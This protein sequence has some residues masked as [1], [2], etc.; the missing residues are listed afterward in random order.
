M[1][2]EFRGRYFFLSNFFEAPVVYD[3]ISY[4]NNEAAFQAQKTKT[5]EERR[6][7][8]ELNPSEA[9]RLGRRVDLCGD[10]ENVKVYVM[11][12]IVRAKF[13]QNPDLGQKL[14]DTNDEQ[15]VE[16]NTWGDR[17]W[18]TVNGQGQNRLGIIL[19]QIRDELRNERS[20]V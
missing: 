11:T 8:S 3:G 14:L 12:D 17:Y 10:W 15:L 4:R 13:T 9:K 1:I 2:N 19:M 5:K 20:D 6:M 7:F 16:G 18:G